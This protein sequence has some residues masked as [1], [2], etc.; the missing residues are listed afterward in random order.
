M[1]GKDYHDVINFETEH[2][3]FIDIFVVFSMNVSRGTTNATTYKMCLH[4]DA[5]LCFT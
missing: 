5:L 3:V 2:Y 4:V 1:L